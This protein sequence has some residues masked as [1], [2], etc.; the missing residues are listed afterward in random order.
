MIRMGSILGILKEKNG[1]VAISNIIFE[2]M[3]SDIVFSKIERSG[4]IEIPEKSQFV[5]DGKLDMVKILNKFHLRQKILIR[6]VK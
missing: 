6:Q 1:Q 2:K 5:S 4:M 3:L